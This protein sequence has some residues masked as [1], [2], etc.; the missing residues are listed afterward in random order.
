MGTE[1]D[2]S[3]AHPAVKKVQT[4]HQRYLRLLAHHS[5]VLSNIV[6]DAKEDIVRMESTTSLS[7]I[8]DIQCGSL[9]DDVKAALIAA[10][11][12]YEEKHQCRKIKRI[13]HQKDT[14]KKLRQWV[15]ERGLKID[16]FPSSQEKMRLS[17]DTGLT[18][19]Q[20]DLWFANYR[21]RVWSKRKEGRLRQTTET[22]PKSE[23]KIEEHT[24]N[25][26]KAKD[27]MSNHSSVS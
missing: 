26:D 12:C 15:R 22:H 19:H 3:S 8:L 25:D 13:T 11:K 20:V 16:P 21:K 14:T 4:T 27:A 17:L 5:D 23:A 6:R 24:A 10:V 18:K 9:V 1:E 2:P 7:C